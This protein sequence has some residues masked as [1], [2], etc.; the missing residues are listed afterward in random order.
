[1]TKLRRVQADLESA[2]ERAD[3]AEQAARRRPAA[4]AGG[5]A[6]AGRA[7]G[8]TPG[9]S[10]SREGDCWRRRTA[11]RFRNPEPCLP[12]RVIIQ[13]SSFSVL[14]ACNIFFLLTVQQTRLQ[15]EKAYYF[16]FQMDFYHDS[17]RTWFV[18]V[19][20]LR[21]NSYF[22]KDHVWNPLEIVKRFFLDN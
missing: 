7:G 3:T 4:S 5:R 11:I 17:G 16:P 9:R 8:R 18:S 13:I 15:H 12:C 21:Q 1:M 2:E 10:S 6:S 20:K 22:F 19:K 14:L